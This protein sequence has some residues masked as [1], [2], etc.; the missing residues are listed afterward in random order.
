LVSTPLFL[1]AAF[2]AY[3]IAMI[4]FWAP[5]YAF[6]RALL[7]FVSEGLHFGILAAL[8]FAAMLI[9]NAIT[10]HRRSDIPF[11]RDLLTVQE[12]IQLFFVLVLFAALATLLLN[13]NQNLANSGLS[14]NYGVLVRDFG[15]EV[16]EGPDPRADWLFLQRVPLM[17]DWLYNLAI[18]TPDTYFR[19]LTAGF[20]NT[21][22]VV[23]LSL[24]AS[25]VLG[26]MLGIGLL[27]QN[28]LVRS[29][30]FSWV[31]IFRNTP[32]L[33]QLFFMYNG[34]IRLLPSSPDEAIAMP[35]PTYLSSRG[36][37]YPALR[38]TPT[39]SYFYWLLFIGA[40]IGI[41]LWQWRLRVNEQTGKPANGFWYFAVSTLGLGAVG[42]V[43][44]L[45][46]GGIPFT[47][48]PPTASRFNFSGG[49]SLSGEY[50]GLFLGL[51]FYTSA[52]IADIVR[53]G[54][55]SVAKGQVEASRALG[56]SNMQ[57]LNQIILPQALRL[58]VPPLTNQYLNLAKN[59]S[60]GI[61]I[62]FADLFTVA[63]IA[64]NQ[65]GQSVVMF[66]IL[67]VTYLVLS[68]IISMIMNIFN[69]SLRLRTR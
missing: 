25:T 48:E 20:M 50:L 27:S 1:L 53:A 10:R 32:L 34:V 19:A 60:L 4:V 7:P 41:G 39:S 16:S 15:T 29:V 18:V 67:M 23:W 6:T 44:A 43:I 33:V 47:F 3:L 36:F 61:A 64:N 28:W 66:S 35:G 52:F 49:A 51:T 11:Y 5:I 63:N 2:V 17:G 22:R 68:L 40:V 12:I 59:S 55:Q 46:M 57:T 58:A 9:V 56:L 45:A 13:L 26:V 24:A 14:V 8:P 69:S 38:T 54:I 62:G 21:L 65:T 37:Y 42:F 30:S 31:E